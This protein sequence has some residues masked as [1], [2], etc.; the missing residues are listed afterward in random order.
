[1]FY[2]FHNYLMPLYLSLFFYLMFLKIFFFYLAFHV[3]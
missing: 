3:F 1:M 2:Y